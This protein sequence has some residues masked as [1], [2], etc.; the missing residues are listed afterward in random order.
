MLRSKI[1]KIKYLATKTTL[2]AKINDV[3]GQIPSI[4]K[5]AT[6]AALNAKINEVRNKIP[7]INN[8]TTTTTLTVVEN[9]ISSVSNLLKKLTITK[10]KNW[11]NIKKKIT[12]HDKYITTPEFNKLTAKNIAAGLVQASLASKSDVANFVKKTFWW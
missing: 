9:K 3:R 10:H 8:L 5:L 6:T 1:L 4:T 12:D 11:W 7:N 2:N